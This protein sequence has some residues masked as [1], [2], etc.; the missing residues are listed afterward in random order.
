MTTTSPRDPATACPRKFIATRW[1]YSNVV[2]GREWEGDPLHEQSYDTFDRLLDDVWSGEVVHI[3]QA[4]EIDLTHGTAIEITDAIY[5]A[6]A[7]HSYV[8]G[9]EP[10]DE[11]RAELDARGLAYL[12]EA[13]IEREAEQQRR[14]NRSQQ[15]GASQLGVGRH[16]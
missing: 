1:K 16:G 9:R 5:V 2:V 11:L 8:V 3:T 14:W 12:T 7:D 4:V 15:L 13:D 10:H 6:A